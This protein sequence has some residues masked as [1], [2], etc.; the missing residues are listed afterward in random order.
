M[1]NGEFVAV[2]ELDERGRITIPKEEREKL[3]LKAGEKLI[4]VE[5]DGELILTKV[6]DSEQLIKNLKGCI[7]DKEDQIDPL[8]LKKIWEDSSK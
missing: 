5:R 2:I 7:T 6:V 3:G 4:L 1:G 8:E